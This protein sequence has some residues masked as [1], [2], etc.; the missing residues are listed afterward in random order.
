MQYLRTPILG[1]FFT[2][3]Y[4]SGDKY[5][6]LLHNGNDNVLRV[7]S[8]YGNPNYA[9]M[10]FVVG[11]ILSLH[12]VAQRCGRPYVYAGLYGA[13]LFLC[14]IAL[15]SRTS[16]VLLVLCTVI[17]GA[18][19]LY[20][21][22][23]NVSSVFSLAVKAACVCTALAW[24][25]SLLPAKYCSTRITE[26]VVAV[27]RSGGLRDQTMIS[28]GLNWELAWQAICERGSWSIGNGPPGVDLVIDSEFLTILYS[29]GIL[30]IGLLLVMFAWPF[31]TFHKMRLHASKNTAICFLTMFVGLA[32]FCV[33]AP[34]LFSPKLGPVL[35]L[36]LGAWQL[37][38]SGEAG[39]RKVGIEGLA[40]RNGGPAHGRPRVP[41]RT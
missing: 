3:L 12:F 20:V 26:F 31:G 41:L 9:G 28:R 1:T 2:S 16:V 8:T 33:V 30:G 40:I 23:R 5:L 15:R 36:L 19:Y 24:L 21:N 10:H 39:S 17:Y 29:Q 18:L 35:A 11:A 14:V 22:Y 27:G 6:E 13:F 34:I 37:L 38:L 7:V 25:Y 32:V 4:S